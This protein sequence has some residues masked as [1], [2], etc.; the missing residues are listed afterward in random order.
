MHVIVLRKIAL[1]VNAIFLV[2]GHTKN[3]C[4]RKFNELKIHTREDNIYTPPMLFEAL[5]RQDMVEAKAFDSF[6]DWDEWQSRFMKQNIPGIKSYHLFTVDANFKDGCVMRRYKHDGA[7]ADDLRVITREKK[8]N[9]SWVSTTPNRLSELGLTD[10]KHVEL[11]DKWRP[12][13]PQNQWKD[14]RY[15][16]EAPT[17][18]KRKN[19]NKEE[20]QSKK[21]RQNRERTENTITAQQPQQH[22][23]PKATV[24][25][26]GH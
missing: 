8:E 15:L 5:N 16:K 24:T 13:I 4:D 1:R 11:Y 26:P 12:L 3:P 18:S 2:K 17:Q 6:F 21:A 10:I 25:F 19:V 20:T 22:T 9:L 14:F 23:Q 7:V